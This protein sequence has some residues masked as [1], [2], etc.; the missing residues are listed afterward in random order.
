MRK[1]LIC[2]SSLSI[3]LL[4]ACT[5]SNLLPNKPIK[6]I[7]LTNTEN[8]ATYYI[9]NEKDI[10]VFKNAFTE[11]KKIDGV[12]D[13]QQQDYE[14]TFTFKNNDHK[15][16]YMWL[17]STAGMVMDPKK[18]T[19]GYDLNEENVKAIHSLWN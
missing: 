13:I 7:V 19:I 18:S 4:A 17:S 6:E 10:E 16:L 8:G 3:L 15:P 2:L 12:I 11:V 5:N 14:V 9:T 1:V